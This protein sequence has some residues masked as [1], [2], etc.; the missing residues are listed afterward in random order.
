MKHE[1]SFQGKRPTSPSFRAKPGRSLPLS[2]ASL[3]WLLVA[4]A[5]SAGARAGSSVD[6]VVDESSGAA[7]SDEN[8]D[9]EAEANDDD[10]EAANEPTADERSA[11]AAKVDAALET[12]KSRGEADRLVI[13]QQRNELAVVSTEIDARLMSIAG[14]E[15]RIDELLGAGKAERERRGE[16]VDLLANLIAT[17]SPQ[18]AATMLAQMSDAQA[19]DLLFSVA[20]GDKRKAAKLIATMPPSRAAAIGQRY[21][22]RDATSPEEV[23]G[24]TPAA[25]PEATKVPPPPPADPP[26]APAAAAA[27]AEPTEEATP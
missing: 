27:A 7:P 25:A 24:D 5:C 15:N 10:G 22:T 16:R 3:L 11:A 19:Q 13:A 26:A 9:D 12:A 18:A 6:E 1:L 21:L 17:M 2:I 23:A 4:T 8:D 14:L 20:Q